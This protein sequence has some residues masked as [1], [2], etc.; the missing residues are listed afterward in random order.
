MKG[1]DILINQ[2]IR[3]KIK[4]GYKSFK[5]SLFFIFIVIIGFVIWKLEFSKNRE[6]NNKSQQSVVSSVLYNIE[7]L[8]SYTV[9]LEKFGIKNNGTNPVEASKGIN[10]ALQFAKEKGFKKVIMPFGDYVINEVNPIIMVDNVVLDLNGSTFRINENGLQG[11]TIVNFTDCKNAKLINGTLL[12]D[13]DTHDYKTISGS[14]E[15]CIGVAFND[16]ENCELNNVT[17]K[18][19]PG[20]GIS[21]SLGKNISDLGVTKS[22]LEI[23]S[24]SEK[25]ILTNTTSTIRTIKPMNISDVGNEFELGYNKGYMGYPFMGAKIYDSYFYDKDMKFI[26]ATKD[27]RQY[28]KV[29]IPKGAMYVNFVF[30]QSMVPT[31]GDTDFDSATVFL[32]NYRSPYKVRITNCL[33]EGNKSLGMALCGGRDFTIENNTFKNNGGSAPGYAIDMEDGWEYMDKFLFKGNKFINN[34]GD[35]VIC[36]GDNISFEDNEFTSAVGVWSR[37]TNYKFTNNKFTNINQGID[38]QYSSDAVITGNT[39]TNSKLSISAKN[40]E[41]KIKIENEKLIN[42]S[43]NTMSENAQI[44]NSIITSDSNISVRLA[45]AYRNCKINS[46]QGDYISAKLYNCEIKDTNLNS[47]DNTLFDSCGFIHSSTYTT[48]PTKSIKVNNCKFTDSNF[49]I[50][51]WGSAVIIDI[52]NSEVN[53]LNGSNSFIEISA[54]KTANLIFKNNTINNKINKPIFNMF[55]TSYSTPNSS[56][57]MEGNSFTQTKY[58]YIFDGENINTGKVSLTNEDNEVQGAE[59]LSAKYLE[60]KNFIRVYQ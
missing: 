52:Q 17:V 43:I 56:I 60:N 21:S 33:I 35:V 27:C 53:M 39:Y 19:F 25:G 26:S 3:R 9:D 8:S 49:T 41:S 15:W 46:K 34:A 24:I 11:Y 32:T 59:I 6:I 1:V 31:K 14:H 40:N 57:T 36:A 47:Q 30:H 50:N 20:Y 45:G 37:A 2:K 23:G 29:T 38:Y 13:K 10:K 7:S 18:N 12:G 28:K 5:I 44:E 51:T 42:T 48:S 16:S 22:N 55:D 54:G 58:P 4:E